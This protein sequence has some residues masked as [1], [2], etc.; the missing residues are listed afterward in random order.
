MNTVANNEK[1]ARA[2]AAT[3]AAP[4]AVETVRESEYV[5]PAV[6]VFETPEGY[7]LEAEMPGVNKE[8]LMLSLEGN[9]LEIE[10]R[11]QTQGVPGVEPLY[12]ESAAAGFHRVFQLD[13]AIETAKI[14]A[15]IEQGLLTVTLPKAEAV[16]PRKIAVA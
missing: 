8:G 15:K 10:G 14:S 4:A 5:R 3:D 9:L 13:P 2:C 16:K 1:Q 6:N 11:R 12:R 7:V